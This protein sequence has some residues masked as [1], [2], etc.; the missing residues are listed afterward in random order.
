V[1]LVVA[2]A[3]VAVAFVLVAEGLAVAQQILVLHQK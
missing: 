2:A 1:R 3:A